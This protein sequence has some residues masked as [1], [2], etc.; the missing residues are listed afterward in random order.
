VTVW[1]WVTVCVCVTVC[2]S[3]SAWVT[4]TVTPV[5]LG[6]RI[7][8]GAAV[9]VGAVVG[10]TVVA[11]ELVE[12]AAVRGGTERVPVRAVKSEPVLLPAPHPAS[13][14]PS[15]ASEA[16]AAARARRTTLLT[17]V[18]PGSRAITRTG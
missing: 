2:V 4:V 7:P 15:A 18:R 17:V 12:P 5:V 14:N 6:A 9:V 8:G 10:A 11:A 1:A 16:H 3:V 13:A